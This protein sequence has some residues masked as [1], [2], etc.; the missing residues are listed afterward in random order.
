MKQFIGVI[1]LLIAI[2]QG[3][4]LTAQGERLSPEATIFGIADQVEVSVS[5]SKPSVKGRVIWG[6]L[7]P[8]ETVWRAGANE[9]TVIEFSDDVEILGQKLPQ[10]RYAFFVIPKK[11]GS[12]TAI[13]NSDWDQWGAYKHE[14]KK[15][16]LRVTNK[17]E[18]A[19]FNETLQF[20]ID[21]DTIVLHWEKLKFKLPIKRSVL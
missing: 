11:D 3:N 8:Y 19:S 15:D 4:A 20:S 6:D 9:A 18:T 21:A 17:P 10:G 14:P 5:Y 16:V 1:I 2:F 7:V 13:F 12:W